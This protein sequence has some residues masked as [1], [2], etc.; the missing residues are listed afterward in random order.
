LSWAPDKNIEDFLASYIIEA[1]KEE[2]E[3]NVVKELVL[4]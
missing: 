4:I 1:T 3:I 2:S